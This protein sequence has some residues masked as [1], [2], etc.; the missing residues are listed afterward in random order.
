MPIPD[1]LRDLLNFARFAPSADNSQPWRFAWDGLSLE[2]LPAPPTGGPFGATAHPTLLAVGAVTADL[3]QCFERENLAYTLE[4]MERIDAQSPYLSFRIRPEETRTPIGSP[5]LAQHYVRHTNRFPYS[6]EPMPADLSRIVGQRQDSARAMAFLEPGMNRRL[7]R[8]VERCSAVRFQTRELHEWLIA[9]LRWSDEE[10][11]R[12]DGLDVESLAMPVGGR[13]FLRLVSNWRTMNLLNRLGA[14]RGLAATEAALVSLAP[15]LVCI[16]GNGDVRGVLAAG[17]LLE[18]LWTELNEKGLA[19]QPYYVVTDQ[20]IRLSL[21]RVP[22]HLREKLEDALAPLPSL[23]DFGS[24]E[25]LHMILRVGWPT[26]NP[27]RSQRLTLG[28]LLRD[29]PSAAR[30]RTMFHID[31]SEFVLSS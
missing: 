18:K 26:V 30:V 14:Y 23:L 19:V 7:G 3:T 27:K 2:V 6:K 28:A 5:S 21:Q 25:M 16:V 13:A 29:R 15:A 22:Q 31:A 11:S 17:Q 20:Q 4:W 9:S 12:G 8:I 10:A 24:G 1:T